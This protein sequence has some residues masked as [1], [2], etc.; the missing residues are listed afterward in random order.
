MILT[1][2]IVTLLMAG[3]VAYLFVASST[4][5]E[6]LWLVLGAALWV[7]GILA[8]TA[9]TLGQPAPEAVSIINGRDVRVLSYHLA[10][11]EAI[12]LW[13]L[14]GGSDVPIYYELPWSEG[15]ARE[16]H[17]AAAQG[18]GVEAR[19]GVDNELPPG[20]ESLEDRE[21]MF[22]PAPVQPLPEKTGE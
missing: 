12:Y 2:T 6:R 11:G 4:R 10:P 8:L 1:L 16:L 9:L 20:E 14:T 15:D 5:R 22:W 3:G 13:T 19:I 17:E 21:P 7:L 18:Q